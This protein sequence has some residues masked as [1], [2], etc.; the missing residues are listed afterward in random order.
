[1]YVQVSNS[2]ELCPG[3]SIVNAIDLYKNA[4]FTVCLVSFKLIQLLLYEIKFLGQVSFVDT[5]Q[6]NVTSPFIHDDLTFV[7]VGFPETKCKI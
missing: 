6:V 7:K 5:F 3:T 4:S 2:R 1:M